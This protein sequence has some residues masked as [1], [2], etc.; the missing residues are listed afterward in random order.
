MESP[1]RNSPPAKKQGTEQGIAKNEEEEELNPETYQHIDNKLNSM[2]KRLEASLSA[3]LSESITKSV[4]DSLKDLIDNSLKTALD[5]MSKNVD[6]AIEKNPTV[7]QH[8][9][10]IDSL[11][12]ENL[13]LKSRVQTMEGEHS[14]MKKKLSE[15]EKK[16]LQ[17]NMI[18]KGIEEDEWE[19]EAVSRTKIYS[20]LCKLF[21]GNSDGAKLK[22]AKRLQIRSCRRIGRYNKD[23]S[24]PISVEFLRKEDT[25]FIFTNKSK[26]RNG[27]YADRE[28]P[29]EIEKKRKLLRPILTVAK[30]HKKFRKRCKLENDLLVIKGKKY[31]LKKSDGVKDLS[32]L[33]RPLK[34][35]KISSR[36]NKEIYGYF[37]ELNPLSNFHHAPFTFDGFT[38]HC[39]K[40]FIQKQKAELFKDKSAIK[41][42]EA[43]TTGLKCKQEGSR[44]TNYKKSSWEKKAKSLC[45]PGIKQKFLEN[46]QALTTLLL[47]TSNKTIVECTKDSV[48]GCGL[49][50]QDKN[51]LIKTKW[52]N[53]GIMGEILQEIRN[54]LSHLSTDCKLNV[55]SDTGEESDSGSSTSSETSMSNSISEDSDQDPNDAS[56]I[57]GNTVQMESENS[58]P[59]AS[60]SQSS[61]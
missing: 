22:Q 36:T 35:S 60:S 47:D 48:W 38:Y 33:P 4:T 3:S 39:S 26:L 24:R 15:I 56:T 11:E 40:Q 57:P 43:A 37:G 32:N 31:G 12:T 44:I 19:E 10:Q 5:T 50:L 51:C 59:T 7:I 34:P 1:T 20:E 13:L 8:G 49:A 14:N 61:A 41:R 28:Y 2:E 30:K 23:R 21:N 54:E 25:D 52:T 55:S 17:Q 42:I 29:V 46:R 53:Q 9:E 27:I 6:K 45:K 18:F 16:A 58:D